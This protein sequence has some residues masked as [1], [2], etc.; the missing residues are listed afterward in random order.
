MKLTAA[1]QPVNGACVEPA[2]FLHPDRRFV[3]GGAAGDPDL[4]AEVQEH[5][6]DGLQGLGFTGSRNGS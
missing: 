1:E 6:A 4:R 5:F 2:G 3:G